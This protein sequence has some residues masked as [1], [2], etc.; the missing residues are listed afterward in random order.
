MYDRLQ[1]YIREIKK[2]HRIS[3]KRRRFYKDRPKNEILDKAKTIYF[4][5][6]HF[7]ELASIFFERES[8][9]TLRVM[10]FEKGSNLRA[11]RVICTYDINKILDEK[12]NVIFEK[13]VKL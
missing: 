9:D 7:G 1:Y 10:Y 6:E 12:D 3:V 4:N 2:R 11:F 5:T 8:Y 13:S